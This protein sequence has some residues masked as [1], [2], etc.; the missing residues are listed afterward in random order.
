MALWPG[1]G[2]PACVPGQ[3]A[4]CTWLGFLRFWVMFD[5]F[6]LTKGP[7]VG[8]ILYVFG[9]LSGRQILG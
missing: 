2:P 6:G 3:R 5:I 4:R 8:V 1:C 9:G 7:L